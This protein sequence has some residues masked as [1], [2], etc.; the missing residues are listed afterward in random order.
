[1]TAL[2]IIAEVDYAAVLESVGLH[3]SIGQR[4]FEG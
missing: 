1:M 3:W 4:S 2:G